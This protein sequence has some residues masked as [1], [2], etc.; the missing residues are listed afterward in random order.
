M[1]AGRNIKGITVE[2][3]GDT[4]GLDKALKGTNKEIKT[5]ETKL[6]DVNRLLKLD[7]SNTELLRQKHDLLQKEIGE[8]KDKLQVLKEAD[9]QAKKQLD[10]GDLGQDEY[11]A[12][13]RE[14]IETEAK[15]K[16]LEQTAG[17]SSG[18][19]AGISQ[20]AQK[21]SNATGEASKKLMPLTA[22]LTGVAAASVAAFQKVDEGADIVIEKTGATGEAAQ[23]LRDNFENVYSTFPADTTEVGNALGEV[24]TRF[25]KT[26]KELEDTSKLFLKYAKINNK[27]VATSIAN[28]DKIMK[29][30]NV[31]QSQTA[32]LLGL[33]T[34]AGQDTGVSV[35]SLE[36]SVL[37]NN[38]VLKE[39]GLGLEESVSL[40]AQF[41]ANGVDSSTALAGLKKA[42]ANATA[43]GLTLDEALA[44]TIE[45]IQNASTE[46][47]A[48]SIA[49]ELFGN[50]G[51]AE[52]AN[53]IRSGRI[54]LDELNTSME[55]FGSVVDDTFTEIQDPMDEATI[56]MN[57]ATAA[58][59]EIG[60]TLLQIAA[61]AIQKVS[62]LV[63]DFKEWWDGLSES[64]QNNIIMFAG[65]IAILAPV[66]GVISSVSGA[67][68]TVTGALSMLSGAGTFA[69]G[70]IGFLKGGLEALFALITAHPVAAVIAAIIGAITLLYNKCEWFRN[71]VNTAVNAVISVF[72]TMAGNIPEAIETVKQ[73]INDA[74]T[75]ITDAFENIKKG[76]SEKWQEA[77][78]FV[79][80]TANDFKTNVENAFSNIVSA[81]EGK[82][83]SIASA[84]RTAF[85][86]AISYIKNL[87]DEALG[88]GKDM[89][90][91]IA[92][93]IRGKIEE[94]G[95]AVKSVADAISSWLHFSRPEEGPLHEYE[96][97]M[98]DFMKGLAKGIYGNMYLVEDAIGAVSGMMSTPISMSAS[99]LVNE[100]SYKR[101]VLDALGAT[102]DNKDVVNAIYEIKDD[103]ST[104]DEA[105]RSMRVELNGNLVGEIIDDVDDELGN[106][107]TRSE[108]WN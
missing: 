8:T 30:W 34:K 50:K 101:N 70:V 20:T 84:A 100:E 22:G 53:A 24:Q 74:K 106:R 25:K 26:G 23:E 44:S 61:P 43:D 103:I 28:T 52:M 81:I 2:I 31:D 59:A 107:M 46:T 95:S 64:T 21:V 17:S 86:D 6:R 32:D 10:S 67:V 7:P 65:L 48:L 88:W 91:G 47:E 82:A 33:L 105:I 58:G 60:N 76:I 83:S 16:S 77:V 55:G 68:S 11:D 38:A 63:R 73:T 102:G 80:N 19:L 96:K 94:V 98:P 3:G 9:A 1:A 90:Q 75:A 39:M 27:D 41:E 51:A 66:L 15:L 78:N 4:T 97:W 57:A 89:I 45:S 56:A 99:N 18:A 71:G 93:G 40:L 79:T 35:D 5:T 72:K 42:L 12:L 49:A 104:L 54:N 14:I 37:Q 92:D 87:P 62:E 108:R 69:S 36:Q 13:Q 29:A 85:S